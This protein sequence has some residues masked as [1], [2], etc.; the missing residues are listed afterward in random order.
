MS[1]KLTRGNGRYA[2]LAS[3][4][5][6]DDAVMAAGEK[7]EVLFCRALAFSSNADADG[8]ITDRQ[9][10]ALAVG[11]SSIK[12]RIDALIRE[13]LW[14]RVDGGYQVRSWLKWNKP[15]EEIG[16]YRKNDRERKANGFRS[17]SAHIPSGK[18]SESARI[19]GPK[20]LH[21]T[22]I[23]STALPVSQDIGGA[24]SRNVPGPRATEPTRCTKHQD[25]TID[26]GPCRGCMTARENHESAAKTANAE[27]MRIREACPDCNADG[28]L[29][30]EDGRPIARCDHGR[31]PTA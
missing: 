19:P 27:R 30:A 24:S 13:E 3:A 2:P 23:Q 20:V 1:L 11:L 16:R 6:L 9:V 31:I 5:Y 8:F 29:E 4:Y 28:W 22:A 21:G 18:V 15:A 10:T 25:T 26:P 7:A 17:N 14:E 12:A